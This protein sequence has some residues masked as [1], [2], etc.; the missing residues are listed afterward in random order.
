MKRNRFSPVLQLVVTEFRLYIREPSAFFFTLI[1]PLLLMLL[2][3]SIWGNDPFPGATYGYIDAFTS[4]FI[5]LVILTSGVMHLTVNMAS[6]REK[7]ILKRFRATPISPVT[8]LAAQ[9]IA[10]LA[11]TVLGPRF[12]E[13][14]N[15][16]RILNFG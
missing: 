13:D 1:F 4:A 3:G 11:I 15:N 9:L 10:L 7:G 16:G 12:S 5:G 2:F 14:T 8:L 6:Y